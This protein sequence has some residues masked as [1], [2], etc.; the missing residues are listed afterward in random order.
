[1]D[2]QGVKSEII[3]QQDSTS[4]FYLIKYIEGSNMD[5]F[6]TVWL[7]NYTQIEL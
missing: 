7:N 2:D 3:K 4:E 6:E 5:V 1:M